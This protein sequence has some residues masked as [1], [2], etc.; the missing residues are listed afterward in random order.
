ML[1][2]NKILLIIVLLISIS[3]AIKRY[4]E[5]LDRN[6]LVAIG[7]S[8][9]KINNLSDLKSSVDYKFFHVDSLNFLARH[10]LSHEKL[11]KLGY[12]TNYFF[13]SELWLHLDREQQITFKILSSDS[14]E[15]KVNNRSVISEEYKGEVKSFHVS[16]N[17]P[18]GKHKVN[19]KKFQVSENFVLKSEYLCLGDSLQ[20][21]LGISS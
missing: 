16:I 19:I 1:D 4:S 18:K 21:P 17:L 8:E 20:L 7:Q 15:L 13:A 5:P 14:I 9:N 12:F 11:G 3:V 10:E 6:V 2:K